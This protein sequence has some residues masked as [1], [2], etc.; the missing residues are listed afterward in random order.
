MDTASSQVSKAFIPITFMI[1]V[2]NEEARIRYVLEHAVRWADEVIV[3]NKSSTD[4]PVGI[5]RGLVSSDRHST[6]VK[7][8]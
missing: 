4:R 6:G 1:G 5:L 3:V 2:Y 7:C 8:N